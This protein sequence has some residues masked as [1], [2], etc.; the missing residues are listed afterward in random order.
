MSPISGIDEY[1]IH[2]T[3]SPQRIMDNTDPRAFDRVWFSAHDRT[4][5]LLVVC[6][7]GQ[8][9]NV[10]TADAYAICVHRGVLRYVRYHRAL[11]VDR[12]NMEFGP[13]RFDLLAPF[14]TWKITLAD[15]PHGFSFELF[16]HDTKR[17]LYSQAPSSMDAT[18]D[19]GRGPSISVGYETFGRIEGV[20]TVDGTR[21][22]L[23]AREF[24][25]SRDHHWGVRRGVGGFGE[26]Q[27][28]GPHC[29]QFVEFDNWSIW[30]ASI[31]KNLRPFDHSGPE[32]EPFRPVE[33]R[34]RF[35]EDTGEVREALIT[36]V[37]A[38]GSHRDLHYR[39]LGFQSAY[40]RCG[41][42][43]RA[44]PD[45]GGTHGLYPGQ[46]SLFGGTFD[47]KD[48]AIR[49]GLGSLTQHHCEVNCGSE[50]TYGTLEC[51]EPL[52]RTQCANQVPGYKYW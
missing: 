14:K 19:I 52:V 30:G 2:N 26:A 33:R 17:A 43:G 49:R 13:L 34:F 31:G 4:G 40:L 29:G 46:D 6:G 50:T 16:W 51:F 1:L 22:S 3:L 11:G 5:D 9:P 32:D 44:T 20:A 36:V 8:Y 28:Y 47:L 42:Y 25:G 24:S 39:R 23:S 10:N 21:L 18:T 48:A 27:E 35:D 45:A 38:T 41:G 15:N 37:D 12:Q 7:M